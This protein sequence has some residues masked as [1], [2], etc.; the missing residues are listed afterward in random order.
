ISLFFLGY[1]SYT[2]IREREVADEISVGF[3]FSALAVRLAWFAFS[4]D[5]SV[6]L[7]PFL[8]SL[9]FLA[10]SLVFY[11]TKQWGGG[12][13]LVLVALG[14]SFGT[15]PPEFPA[16]TLLP[17]W[18][19]LL[20]NVFFVGAIYGVV[21]I[22][23]LFFSRREIL[24]DAFLRI[25]KY[26]FVSL[27]LA[28]VSTASVLIFRFPE[29]LLGALLFFL[30]FALLSSKSAEAIA[31]TRKV[32]PGKLQVEDW[33]SERITSGGRTVVSTSSTG[34][35]KQDIA[36]IMSLA[37]AGKLDQKTIGVKEGIPFVPVFL[38]ALLTTIFAGDPISWMLASLL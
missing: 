25:R 2:D 28:A 27:P 14:A 29:N 38:L 3:L 9:G 6:F 20:M 26:W 37:K 32:S 15:L 35:T 8:V 19:A 31:F 5:D 7:A 22:F 16:K 33:L 36:R 12:D 18:A 23:S 17:F 21:W 11:F 10:L 13:L 4:G 1:A 30:Y 34:L 24:V